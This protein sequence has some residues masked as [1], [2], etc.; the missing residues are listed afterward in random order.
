[1]IERMACLVEQRDVV[2]KSLMRLGPQDLHDLRTVERANLYLGPC[3]TVFFI[4]GEQADQAATAVIHTDECA[5]T[6]NRPRDRMTFDAEIGFNVADEL[7]RIFTRT[8]ALVDKGEDGNSAALADLEKLPRA[9]F[10]ATSVVQKHH[11]TIRCNESPVRV[12][13]KI[14]V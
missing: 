1:M 8:V 4:A 6:K 5:V 11:C 13:G 10:D 3:R 9:L 14:F 2:H 7:E 12:L